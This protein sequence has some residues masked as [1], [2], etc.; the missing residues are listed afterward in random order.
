MAF[1]L[2]EQLNMEY[3]QTQRRRSVHTLPSYQSVTTTVAPPNMIGRLTVTV[4][5][6]KLAKNY[7]FSRM[8]PYCRVRIGHSVFE[9]PICANGSKEPKWNRTF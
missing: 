9:T 2:Q 6:A 8:D 1:A 3:T 7:G 5:E 4:V